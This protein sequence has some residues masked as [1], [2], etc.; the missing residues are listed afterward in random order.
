ML[1][2]EAL[3]K[4]TVMKS[5]QAASEIKPILQH[6]YTNKFN[7]KLKTMGK[8]TAISSKKKSSKPWWIYPYSV[9]WKKYMQRLKMPQKFLQQQKKLLNKQIMSPTFHLINNQNK[10]VD[11]SDSDMEIIKITTVVEAIRQKRQNSA[12]MLKTTNNIQKIIGNK[13]S[14][15]SSSKS[16]NNSQPARQEKTI[17][18]NKKSHNSNPNY[19]KQRKRTLP[20]KKPLRNEN[21]TDLKTANNVAI[22]STVFYKRIW[23]YINGTRPHTDIISGYNSLENNSDNSTCTDKDRVTV[24]QSQEDKTQVTNTNIKP[25]RDFYKR[26]WDIINA[27]QLIRNTNSRSKRNTSTPKNNAVST[28]CIQEETVN[29]KEDKQVQATI[30]EKTPLNITGTLSEISDSGPYISGFWNIANKIQWQPKTIPVV[31]L[32]KLNNNPILSSPV[33]SASE[34]DDLNKFP[35]KVISI[36]Y[37]SIDNSTE[38]TTEMRNSSQEIISEPGPPYSSEESSTTSLFLPIESAVEKPL[39]ETDQVERAENSTG[40]IP[41]YDPLNIPYVEVP[42]YSDQQE[43]SLDKNNQNTT[44]A[45]YK[46]YDD[47]DYDYIPKQFH[48]TDDFSSNSPSAKI[49]VIQT[50][51]DGPKTSLNAN[52]TRPSCTE[53]NDSAECVDNDNI[54]DTKLHNNTE[55]ITDDIHRP[56]EEEDKSSDFIDF[57][58]YKKS[59]NWEEFFKNDPILENIR[60]MFSKK[61]DQKEKPDDTEKSEEVETYATDPKKQSHNYF[62]KNEDFH[63]DYSFN[64]RDKTKEETDSHEQKEAKE[65]EVI[66]KD[67]YPYDDEDFFKDMFEKDNDD[68]ESSDAV[69]T[70]K[71]FLSRYF[72]KNVLHQLKDNSTIEEDRQR[73]ESRNREDIY[74]TLSKILDKKDRFSRLNENL[75]KMI[76]KGEAVPIKYNNFWSLEYESPRKR[77]KDNE[78]ET[79]D[80]KEE[81]ETE[82][83]REREKQTE[84]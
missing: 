77:N 46:E 66:D 81:G 50:E 41:N 34:V 51:S 68:K 37:S 6:T 24:S 60:A 56:A 19:R 9:E 76:E 5:T 65:S 45:R 52:S 74:N 54:E 17:V 31:S 40:T 64:N 20:M 25:E 10:N 27:T 82:R 58:E 3:S 75:N 11:L 36:D 32:A 7:R 42:D 62:T 33:T 59:I 57:D 71:D 43:K 61:Y 38:Y 22:P 16:R 83:E 30:N 28:P 48:D 84:K 39:Q 26:I 23:E 2:F 69:D 53:S 14:K 1:C 67:Y 35:D 72:T 21:S 63:D 12:Q 78:Q 18:S 4:D 15:R 73:E 29:Y 55:N 70:E 8:N 79:E 44:S 80:S 47:S 13:R 49:K